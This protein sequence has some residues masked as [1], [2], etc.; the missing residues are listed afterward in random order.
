MEQPMT[1]TAIQTRF[2][3]YHFR[4]R[5]EARWAVAFDAMG[6]PWQYEQEGFDL[7]I[8]GW[9]L[10]DFWLPKS[11]AFVEIRS[12]P[13]DVDRDLLHSLANRS[14]REVW[15]LFPY[16]AQYFTRPLIAGFR[17]QRY[18]PGSGFDGRAWPGM[19]FGAQ[20]AT[21]KVQ[22]ID[23]LAKGLRAARSARFE[24]GEKGST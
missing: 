15:V 12:G 8:H 22:S 11:P 17:A 5:T 9:Y 3:G 16:E 18:T 19:L 1:L 4:S 23:L 7:A 20:A 13:H 2:K 6:A 24:H 14:G 21:Q 10:P